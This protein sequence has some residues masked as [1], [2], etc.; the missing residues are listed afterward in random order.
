MWSE[1]LECSW[2]SMGSTPRQPMRISL[3]RPSGT[4]FRRRTAPGRSWHLPN[5]NDVVRQHITY[6]IRVQCVILE[7]RN[8]RW[9]GS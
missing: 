7:S 9:R 3:R 8:Y 1:Q 5:A 4:A 2:V 6:L